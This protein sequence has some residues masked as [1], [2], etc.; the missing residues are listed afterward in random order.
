V[1]FLSYFYLFA[2]YPVPYF[3]KPIVFFDYPLFKTGVYPNQQLLTG[4]GQA[5]DVARKQRK[6]LNS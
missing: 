3:I 1:F 5:R 4:P 2:Q 6:E